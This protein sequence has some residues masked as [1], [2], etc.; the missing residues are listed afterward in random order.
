MSVEINIVHSV[1]MLMAI[2]GDEGS[3]ERLAA[4]L[5][6]RHTLREAANDATV[7][8]PIR[9]ALER[10]ADYLDR[11]E[12][13]DGWDHLRILMTYYTNDPR[14]QMKAHR[15]LSIMAPTSGVEPTFFGPG[16]CTPMCP[17][18]GRIRRP[19]LSM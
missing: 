16:S 13:S 6:D 15:L 10:W 7:Y 17:H 8:P 4:I 9:Y 11:E 12:N 5:R 2:R 14:G 3:I 19:E 18:S 1:V